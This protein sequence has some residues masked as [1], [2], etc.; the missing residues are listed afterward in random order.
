MGKVITLFKLLPKKHQIL[1]SILSVITMITMLLP[2]EEA[3]ASRQTAGMSEQTQINTR[4]DV[5]LAFRSPQRPESIE[6]ESSDVP[7]N[8][9][10]LSS[11]DALAAGNANNQ[12]VESIESALH[13]DVEHFNVKN[14]DTL[15]AV[16][17]RAGLTSKDVYEITQLPLAKQNLL[18]IMPGEEIVISKDAKGDLTEVRYRI[19]AISTLVISKNQEQY[20]EKISEKDVEIRTHFTSAKIKSNFWNSAVDAGLNA[21]QIMQLSTVFGWDIDF[22]LDLREGDSFAIIYEQEYAE[23][24]FL[25]NGNILA[26]EFINQ[27][28][29]YTAIRYTDGNYYSE[30]GTSM[31]KAFLRSPVDFKYVSSNFNP[32]RLHPVT[33]QIK[34]HRGVD[35]VAAIGTPIKAA[36]SGRVIESGYNQFNGNYVFIKHNDTYTTK[37]LHLTKRNVS[38]GANVKQG[39][40]IGTLGKTGRVTGAHL[41]YEF[42]VNGVHRNPRTITLPKA[43]SIARKEK[44][45]FDALSR[46]LMA[47]ISQNKQTQLAMQ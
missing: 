44:P 6:G 40:I 5:P 16:F 11:T 4:Y 17:D 15:A 1:L 24:E 18:K 39:Q 27:D 14:G 34:A 29:R 26:A 45:Q 43:E 32:K 25:R 7:A 41:H 42:I 12:A 46:Q 38:K 8:A 35:Y 10:P 2:S 37:Y 36:G 47:T 19:N 28:E 30:N 33:G 31:R 3:Q 22:A 21:N 20:H 13:R 9:E 23:G